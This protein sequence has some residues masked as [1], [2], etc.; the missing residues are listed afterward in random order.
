MAWLNKIGFSLQ[1]EELDELCQTAMHPVWILPALGGL[2]APYWDFTASVVITG[3]T[4]HTQRG[5]V[6]AGALRGLALLMA[7]IVFYTEQFG[8]KNQDIKVSGGLSQV[9]SLLQLQ[10]D[11]LQ[12]RLLPCV[13]KESTAVGAGLLAAEVQGIDT[14]CWNTLRL[15]AEI[16]PRLTAAQAKLT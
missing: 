16:M 4:P 8:L 5:D 11:V 7:D 12:K 2:G 15:A 10:A 3:L 6:A 13:E 1:I 14:S 9:K